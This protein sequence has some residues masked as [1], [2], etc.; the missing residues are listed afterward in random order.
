VRIMAF[1][2][3]RWRAILQV[4]CSCGG[5]GEFPLCVFLG[6]QVGVY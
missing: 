6:F 5:E 1:I 2:V 4:C 3:D